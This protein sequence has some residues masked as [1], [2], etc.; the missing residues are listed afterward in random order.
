MKKVWQK[1]IIVDH[2]YSY[3]IAAELKGNDVF[4][5]KDL[6]LKFH[7]FVLFLG[8]F[9]EFSFFPK[10]KHASGDQWT[11]D[12]KASFMLAKN[13]PT[14]NVIELHWKFRNKLGSS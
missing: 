6:G 3:S 8:Y 11:G 1:E 12:S 9:W 14:V 5:K 10:S 2:F 7:F 4:N 13:P